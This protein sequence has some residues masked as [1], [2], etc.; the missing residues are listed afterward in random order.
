[1]TNKIHEY[2]IVEVFAG[3]TIQ[4]YQIQELGREGWEL[5]FIVE[6]VGSYTTHQLI[7]TREGEPDVRRGGF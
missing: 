5:K 4:E 1:M 7:F 3:A 6:P 2:Q